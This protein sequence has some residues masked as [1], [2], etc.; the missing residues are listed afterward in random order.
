MKWIYIV[1]DTIDGS[2][3]GTNDETA[4]EEYAYSDDH[5]VIDVGNMQWLIASDR[6]DIRGLDE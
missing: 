4:A 3:R 6:E 5:Y 1:I 2:V